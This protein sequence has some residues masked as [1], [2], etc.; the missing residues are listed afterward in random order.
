MRIEGLP[1]PPKTSQTGQR[2]DVARQKKGSGRPD[3]VVEISRSAQEVADLGALAKAAPE[4]LSPRI[5]EVRSRV[6]SGYYDSQDVRREIAGALLESDGLREVVGD[7]SQAQ[8]ARRKLAEIPDTRP[9]QVNQARQ[10]VGSGFYDSEQ[11]RQETAERIL[12][13]LA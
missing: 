1:Q 5:Q 4:E 13:E 2:S 12:D 8:V 3:D 9:E 10:R 7:V 6:Q 11:V